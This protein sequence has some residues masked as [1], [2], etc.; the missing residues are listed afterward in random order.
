MYI[1]PCTYAG[2]NILSETANCISHVLVNSQY[3]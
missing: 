2:G 3:L 1:I